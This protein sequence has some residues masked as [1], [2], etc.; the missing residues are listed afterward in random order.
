MFRVNSISKQLVR[1]NVIEAG[2]QQLVDLLPKNF[3]FTEAVTDQMKLLEKDGVIRVREI[4]KSVSSAGT[5]KSESNA[6]VKSDAMEGKL[7]F[8][9]D[10]PVAKVSKVKKK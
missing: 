5:V 4:R 7:D 3:V 1:L 10:K 9:S 2:R 8:V 6:E